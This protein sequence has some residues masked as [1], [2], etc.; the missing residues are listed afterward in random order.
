MRRLTAEAEV[1]EV[2]HVVGVHHQGSALQGG[3]AGGQVNGTGRF[4]HPA[5]L[6][7]NR[8]NFTHKWFGLYVAG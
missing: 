5:F 2:V 3:E 7:G 6:V 8:Y 1:L 4:A